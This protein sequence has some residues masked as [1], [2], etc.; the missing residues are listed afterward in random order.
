MKDLIAARL[1]TGRPLHFEV[2]DVSAAR[3]RVASARASATGTGARR[4]SSSC[5]V[6][7]GCDGFHGICRDSI[8][9]G[10]LSVFSRDYPF[11]WLGIL[12]A[13][14][15]VERGADLLPGTSAASRSTACASP[16]LTRL[17]LQCAPR[18]GR[19]GVAGRADLGGA[20]RAARPRRLDAPRGPDPRE[21]RHRDAELR[22]RADAARPAL[23]R[24]RRGAHRAADRARRG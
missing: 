21:G 23:P 4:S 2:E 12:G 10:A 9:D 6:V 14:R 3:A 11:G 19:R 1:E 20:A 16:Q 17:Y 7:A 8:P 24:G 15:A 18:R 22:R 5:D 13:G